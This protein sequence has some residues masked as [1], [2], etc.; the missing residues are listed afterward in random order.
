MADPLKPDATVL[1]KLGSIAVHA[2]EFLSSDGSHFD[3]EAIRGLVA[4]PEV[5]DWLKQMDAMAFLPK[6]RSDPGAS[7]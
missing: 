7:Q 6:K 1:I 2:D 3:A 4:D 5:A